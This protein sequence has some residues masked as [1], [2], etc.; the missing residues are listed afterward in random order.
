MTNLINTFLQNSIGFDPFFDG[1]DNWITPR[2]SFPFHNIK[3]ESDNK[4]VIE[5][6]LAGFAKEDIDVHQTDEILT[7]EASEHIKENEDKE[8]YIS[9]GI[10]KRWFRK[11]FQLADTVEVKKVKLEN[12]MLY[13]N[14]ECNRPTVDKTFDID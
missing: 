8:E 3:K 9:K 14:L 7:I 2:S 1:I 11:Q 4:Y 10:S 12:G 5:M 13:I 6:A